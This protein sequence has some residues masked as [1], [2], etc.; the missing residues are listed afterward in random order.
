VCPVAAGF[1]MPVVQGHAA[2][3]AVTRMVL[4]GHFT[5]EQVTP[6]TLS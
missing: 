2:L 4:F 5:V 6:N 1:A 3:V